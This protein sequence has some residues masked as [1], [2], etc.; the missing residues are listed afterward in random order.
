M[1]PAL[2]VAVSAALV[3]MILRQQ[4]WWR[5]LVGLGVIALG[6]PAYFFFRNRARRAGGAAV[7]AVIVLLALNPATAQSSDWDTD[8]AAAGK[9][10]WSC[11]AHASRERGWSA[12]CWSR[13]AATSSNDT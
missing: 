10:D 2:F 5:S 4:E 9:P 11:C 3:V 1:V 6:V 13:R 12:N 8:R 7:V